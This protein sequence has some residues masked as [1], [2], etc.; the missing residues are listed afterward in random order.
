MQNN[1]AALSVAV[2][3]DASLSEGAETFTLELDSG[4]GGTVQVTINDTS[5]NTTPAYLNLTLQTA[6]TLDEGQAATFRLTGRNIAQGTTIDYAITSV[7]GTISASDVVP[8]TLTRTVTWNSALNNVSQTQDFIVTLALDE[9]TEGTESFKVVLAATDSASTSTGSLESPTVTITDTSL[10][11]I[12]G[13]QDFLSSTTWVVPD[14]V[15]SVSMLAISGGGG[16][17]GGACTF[18]EYE[19][20]Q[21]VQAVN[22]DM[23]M[24]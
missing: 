15:I 11:P 2:T 23:L 6:S 14:D 18:S 21:A 1:S 5:V 17:G 24:T 4:A 20:D 12:I 16:A 19:L 7:S 13:Q 10:T 8:A 22:L 3:A 9:I